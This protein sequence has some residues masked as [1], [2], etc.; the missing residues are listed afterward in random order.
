MGCGEVLHVRTDTRNICLNEIGLHA[1]N[2]LAILGS[3]VNCEE[4]HDQV[5][6]HKNLSFI[7][8][9]YIHMSSRIYG[10]NGYEHEL[11]FLIISH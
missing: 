2:M 8:N 11:D 1:R 5:N 7:I 3:I 6:E 9:R 4:L 10:A